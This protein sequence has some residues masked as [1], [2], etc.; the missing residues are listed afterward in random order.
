MWLK[1]YEL[2]NHLGNV[3]NVITDRKVPISEVVYRNNF[4]SSYSPMGAT[5][6]IVLSLE[7]ER[8][9]VANA[10][11][12]RQAYYVA[13]TQVGHTYRATCT[14]DLN[15]SGS[16]AFF[17]HDYSV[18]T[19][20]TVLS[21]SSNGTYTIEFTAQST[22]THVMVQNSVATTRTFYLDNFSIE[23]LSSVYYSADIVSYSD[24]YPYG[25]LLPNRHGSEEEYRYG[26]NGMEQD[27]EVKG[28]GNSYTT[29]FRQYDPRV[30][31]WLSLDPLMA[32][33]PGM[34]PYCAFNNNPIYFADPTGL[35][36]DHPR[37]L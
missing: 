27:N 23:D 5:G 25:M 19:N 11:Q 7:A 6:S 34:S 9:K 14:I 12:W 37:N 17:A 22:A 10:D 4:V 33:Y 26:F 15:S 29:E 3:L 13:P 1:F 31:R 28:N 16:V 35:E 21:V 36:G 2:S 8:L 30:G 32:K 18:G 24:Y 20:L